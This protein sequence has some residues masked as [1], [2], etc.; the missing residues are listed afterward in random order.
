MAEVRKET[1]LPMSTNMCVTRF[2][3]IPEAL[4][5]KPID[6]LLA[7][8]HYFGGFAGCQALGPISE[9]AGW[10]LSQHSN[11]HAGIT[12]AAMIHLAACIPQLTLASDT[13]Y[14]WLVDD[15]DVIEGP[16][17]SIRGGTMAIP[18]GLGLGVTLDRDKLARAH[19][20]YEKSGMRGRDDASLMRRIEP[21]W[22]GKPF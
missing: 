17:L 20:T 21:G 19:E 12:M 8:H 7:D 3:D 13:H 4:R 16:K 1:G 15:A 18:P 5:L 9:A 22:D 14:P 11:S 10:R 6:V 2:R